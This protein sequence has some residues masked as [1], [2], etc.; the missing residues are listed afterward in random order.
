MSL[1]LKV[2]VHELRE[3]REEREE[4]VAIQLLFRATLH[5]VQPHA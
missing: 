3:E 4:A 2:Q 1:A 5:Q